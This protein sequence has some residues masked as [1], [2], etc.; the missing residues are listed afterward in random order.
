LFGSTLPV[1]NRIFRFMTIVLPIPIFYK[2][3]MLDSILDRKAPF[4]QTIY[5][6]D[7]CWE[8]V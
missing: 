5:G 7:G 4:E 2:L 3:R 6:P 1:A 8:I